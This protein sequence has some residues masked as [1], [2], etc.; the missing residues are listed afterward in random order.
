[1]VLTER[2]FQIDFGLSVSMHV[3]LDHETRAIMGR[4]KSL[5]HG[6]LSPEDLKRR[7]RDIAGPSVPLTPA[8]TPMSSSFNT[9]S[10]QAIP[11]PSVV[12]GQVGEVL[13]CARF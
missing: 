7:E 2:P 11:S 10:T 8:P 9:A 5:D 3:I 6:N 1:M 13:R 12:K 4:S